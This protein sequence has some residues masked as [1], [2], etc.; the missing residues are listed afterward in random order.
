M[1]VQCTTCTSLCLGCLQEMLLQGLLLTPTLFYSF[2]YLS[3]LHVQLSLKT[4]NPEVVEAF[5][6]VFA[7]ILQQ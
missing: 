7:E 1:S 2:V 4:R 3:T 5:Q 6:K